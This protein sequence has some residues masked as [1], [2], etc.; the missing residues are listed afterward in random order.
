M[1][2]ADHLQAI[3]AQVAT[4]ASVQ[5]RAAYTVYAPLC[6]VAWLI[7]GTAFSGA[8]NL[9]FSTQGPHA[10]LLGA[11]LATVAT[12]VFL[13]VCRA[14]FHAH[15]LHTIA[16]RALARTKGMVTPTPSA[17]ETIL[18]SILENQGIG[19][20][21]PGQPLPVRVTIT[22]DSMH[23]NCVRVCL[24]YNQRVRFLSLHDDDHARLLLCLRP[25]G[26]WH[27]FADHAQSTNGW[28][29]HLTHLYPTAHRQMQWMARDT[30]AFTPRTS[31]N[32][33]PKA[34]TPPPHTHP[35]A[36]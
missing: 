8:L 7:F 31:T 16:A 11:I 10:L 13:W 27:H 22:K 33:L 21:H 2:Y 9:P 17:V 4:E 23:R 28:T 25:A 32:P 5:M 35:W 1:P 19:L 34:Y 24:C 14:L 6:F 30:P 3:D 29:L 15:V 18:T 26:R 12:L 36:L 20:E